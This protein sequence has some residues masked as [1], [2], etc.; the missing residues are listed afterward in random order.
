[1]HRNQLLDLIEDYLDRF[2]EEKSTVTKIQHFIEENESCFE[3][4]LQ[5]GHITGSAWILSADRSH[6]LLTHHRKLNIWVQ[7]GGHA[8]GDSD[9]ARVAMK[10]AEEES[11]LKGL[12][13][14]QSKIPTTVSRMIF[15]IDIHE[16]PARGNDPVHFHYDCRFLLTAKDSDYVVSEESHDLRWVELSE[17]KN[18]TKESSTLRMIKKSKAFQ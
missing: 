15:D 8:D 3:R 1:M 13:F 9:I 17:I 18:L 11:G 7:L 16:I 14:A 6:A 12:S 2:P 5:I 4:E 10:E